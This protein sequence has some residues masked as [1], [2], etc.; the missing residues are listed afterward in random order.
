LEVQLPKSINRLRLSGSG[1]R[2][3]HGGAA[4]QEVVI[5]LLT[6]NKSRQKDISC[7]KVDIIGS[8]KSV[9]TSGQIG[10][11]FYQSE[12]VTEKVKARRLRAAIYNASGELISDVHILD[13][14]SPQENPREREQQ[15]R[16]ILSRQ[17]ESSNGQ[18]VFLK[19]EEQ[20][21]GTSQYTGYKSQ[22]YTMRRSFSTDFDF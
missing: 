15:V 2:F 13:F 9:I 20:V 6:V 3:V 22:R 16:F 1:S 5:P 14:D 7:V 4:L 11:N 17:A 12:P 21:E 19:L 18:D 10:V 8:E